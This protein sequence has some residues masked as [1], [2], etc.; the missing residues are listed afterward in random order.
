M[1]PPT[2]ESPYVPIRQGEAAI[3]KIISTT[4]SFLSRLR[5]RSRIARLVQWRSSC[6]CRYST[7]ILPAIM[8]STLRAAIFI[9]A[10]NSLAL[11]PGRFRAV[12]AG[13]PV[14]TN[15]KS[16]WALSRDE[17]LN[18]YSESRFEIYEKRDF[19]TA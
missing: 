15:A 18:G 1:G 8:T 14:Q 12:K 13:S 2:K 10:L 7:M 17:V 9:I 5:S 3:Y 19:L 6:R 16:V 4:T 11:R